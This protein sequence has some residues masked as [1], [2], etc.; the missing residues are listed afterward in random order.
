MDQRPRGFETGS[1]ISPNLL[2]KKVCVDCAPHLRHVHVMSFALFEEAIFSA[3]MFFEFRE[4]RNLADVS[5][6]FWKFEVRSAF[7]AG[8]S[9]PS[10]C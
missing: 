6:D 8:N 7:S 1:G 3:A 4:T 2:S 5:F 10:F 9:N